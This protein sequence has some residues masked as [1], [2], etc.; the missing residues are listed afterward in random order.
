MLILVRSLTAPPDGGLRRGLYMLSDSR[1]SHAVLTP[2]QPV[3]ADLLT[4]AGEIAD[5]R[6]FWDL[7]YGSNL[8]QKFLKWT[9]YYAKFCVDSI[10]I[11]LVAVRLLVFL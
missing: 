10:K 1:V 7:N 11:G 8:S 3:S 6:T 5:E 4:R 9:F 2:L